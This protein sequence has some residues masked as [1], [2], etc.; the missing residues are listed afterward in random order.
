MANEVKFGLRSGETLT[1]TPLQP[2]GSARGA[3]DQSMTET[4]STGYYKGTPSTVLKAGDVVIVDDGS[5]KVGFGEFQT[6]VNCE[7]IEGEDFTETLIGA[8]GDTLE[9]LSGQLDGLTSSS[10]KN[11]I[12]Y[13]PKE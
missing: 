8:D 2:D 4:G 11:T 10:F 3:A 1:F 7:L 12:V 6:G 5:N 13:G 9:T